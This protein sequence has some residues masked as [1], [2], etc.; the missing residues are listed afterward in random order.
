MLCL[1]C[2]QWDVFIVSRLRLR[3]AYLDL[4]LIA[5]FTKVFNSQGWNRQNFLGKLNKHLIYLIFS[6]SQSIIDIFTK[7]YS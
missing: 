7:F 5:P 1:A 6:E 4:I 3:F 2:R